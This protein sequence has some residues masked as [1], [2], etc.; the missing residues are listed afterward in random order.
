MPPFNWY[1]MVPADNVEYLEDAEELLPICSVCMG[2]VVV[3]S[4]KFSTDCANTMLKKNRVVSSDSR[5][6]KM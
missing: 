1:V 5:R 6:G 3:N 4:T 2:V